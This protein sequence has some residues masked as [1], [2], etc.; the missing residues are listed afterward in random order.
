[1]R[2]LETNIPDLPASRSGSQSN[3]W[4]AGTRDVRDRRKGRGRRSGRESMAEGGNRSTENRRED[5]LVIGIEDIGRM[6]ANERRGDGLSR[7]QRIGE[8]SNINPSGREG[9]FPTRI[10][11]GRF[12]L[13]LG[14]GSARG[15]IRMIKRSR[16]QRRRPKL[17]RTLRFARRKGQQEPHGGT[18]KQP[19]KG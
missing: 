12:G 8:R 17:S 15:S 1:M 14:N 3:V 18:R 19:S 16:H 5:D 13:R 11:G 7:V 9:N 6:R 4:L 2:K 10:S